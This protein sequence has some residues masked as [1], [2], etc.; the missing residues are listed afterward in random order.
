MLAEELGLTTKHSLWKGLDDSGSSTV[1]SLG[2]ISEPSPIWTQCESSGET[3]SEKN[4]SSKDVQ[5]LW[6]QVVALSAP[7]RCGA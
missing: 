1:M 6:G 4:L 3:S 5:A 2:S 7:R